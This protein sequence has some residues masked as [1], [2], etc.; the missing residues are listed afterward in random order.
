MADRLLGIFGDE[1][2]QLGLGAFMLSVRVIR[3]GID[4]G[5]FSPRI[6]AAHVYDPHRLKPWLWWID[7]EQT[8]GL[9]AFNASPEFS[10]G[11]NDQ[12]LIEWV[13]MGG[14]LDPFAAAR[15]DHST[16][17]LVA[18]THMLCCSCAM[19]FSAAAS[20]ENAQGSMNFASKTAPPS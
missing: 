14:D 3:A 15:N 2:L 20:S 6:R 16:A 13:R 17:F 8:R 18:T 4:R 7:A 9:A 19:Y 12:M 10:L 1:A 11:R 5:K